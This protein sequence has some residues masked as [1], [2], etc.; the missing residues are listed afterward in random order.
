M[1]RT[2][3][4]V[5]IITNAQRLGHLPPHHPKPQNTPVRNYL[6]HPAL[7]LTMPVSLADEL[8]AN[9]HVPAP[10]NPEVLPPLPKLCTEELMLA[11]ANTPITTDSVRQF[12]TISYLPYCLLTTAWKGQC[13]ATIEDIWCLPPGGVHP[14]W[15]HANHCAGSS[16]IKPSTCSSPISRSRSGDSLY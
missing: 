5:R 1:T 6:H 14:H 3:L 2:N 9:S 4:L 10:T 16:S 13:V 8:S 11:C 12:T 7:R 15:T